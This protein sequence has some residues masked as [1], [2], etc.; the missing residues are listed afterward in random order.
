MLLKKHFE[1]GIAHIEIIGHDQKH[2][3]LIFGPQG[4]RLPRDDGWTQNAADHYQL[5][6]KCN[7]L[8]NPQ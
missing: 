7:Q 6:R 4:S 5:G 2:N 1:T 3:T 8:L